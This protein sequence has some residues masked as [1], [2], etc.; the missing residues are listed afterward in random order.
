MTGWQ[1][2]PQLQGLPFNCTPGLGGCRLQVPVGGLGGSRV[3]LWC[4]D[5]QVL[6]FEAQNRGRHHWLPREWIPCWWWA[7]GALFY[8]RGRWFSSQTLAYE[9]L[10][11]AQ[12]GK[13]GGRER[14]RETNILLPDI[15][16]ANAAGAS[17]GGQGGHGL[18]STPQPAEDVIP[19][20]LTGRL[21]GRWPAP[22]S[23]GGQWL[24]TWGLKPT[25][26]SQD[27][28]EYSEGLFHDRWAGSLANG[29][30]LK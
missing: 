8:P 4:S 5:F 15:I 22:N 30:N 9:A 24:S 17:H 3:K 13:K 14:L 23:V 19:H 25:G 1:A 6:W 7:K 2:L 20:R 12:P 16:E 28:E 27:T 11:Q 21:W 26:G 18:P 10:L 29:Q